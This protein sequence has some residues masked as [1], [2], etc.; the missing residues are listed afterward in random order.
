[1]ISAKR[2]IRSKIASEVSD[3]DK[4]AHLLEDGEADKGVGAE[5]QVGR[6]PAAEEGTGALDLEGRGEKLERGPR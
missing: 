4:G 1:M 2:R 5:A 3:A 6:N